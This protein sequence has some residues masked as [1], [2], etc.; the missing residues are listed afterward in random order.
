MRHLI[1]EDGGGIENPELI[2]TNFKDT[3]KETHYFLQFDLALENNLA[4][5][6]EYQYERRSQA[7]DFNLRDPAD[8]IPPAQLNFT[9]EWDYKNL[10]RVQANKHFV[11]AQN[12]LIVGASYLNDDR[13]LPKFELAKFE[14]VIP[15]LQQIKNS[16]YIQDQQTLLD[17]K[18]QMTFGARYDDSDLYGSVDT[19]RG[20]VQYNFNPRYSIKLLYGEAFREPDKFQLSNNPNLKPA[21]IESTEFVLDYTPDDNLAAKLTIYS[22]EAKEIIGED[23]AAN[24]GVSRNIGKFDTEGGELSIKWQA[25]NY[26]GMLWGAI[27]DVSADL[28]VA[29]NKAGFNLTRTFNAH[30]DLSIIG[31]YTSSVDTEAFDENSNREII[32]VGSYKTVDINLSGHELSLGSLSGD[33]SVSM[34]I[35]NLFDTE[36]FYAN[37]RGPDPRQFLDE[38]RSLFIKADYQF[39]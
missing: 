31:K 35:Y 4:M 6:Y 28:D 21:T 26:E 11:D 8:G 7:F 9:Q 25:G 15:Y 24:D 1:S 13:S 39:N 37:I 10:L 32:S 19:F 16:L 22:N 12:Y 36:N 17:G 18:L 23:R 30:W 5:T 3:L 14:E 29:E 33:L 27:V 2:F 38:G 20:S 34:A